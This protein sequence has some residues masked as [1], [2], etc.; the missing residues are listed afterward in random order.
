MDMTKLYG[1]PMAHPDQISAFAH[2]RITVL[3]PDLIRVET[4]ESGEYTDLRSL[5]VA[6]RRF[7]PCPYSLEFG[8]KFVVVITERAR[9]FFER[10]KGRVTEVELYGR[11]IKLNKEKN[12]PGTARTE[13]ASSASTAWRR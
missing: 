12:L 7:S 11:R 2:H 1:D 4:S 6:N 3:E 5:V 13:G 8:E 10:K 9:F